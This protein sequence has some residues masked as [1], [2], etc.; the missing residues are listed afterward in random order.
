VILDSSVLLS[1]IFNEKTAAWCLDQIHQ[2]QSGLQMSTVNL[3]ECLIV[4]QDRQPRDYSNIARQIFSAGI[5]FVPPSPEQ[6]VMAAGARHK[7]PINLG[8][9]FAYALAAWM[10]LPLLT[11]DRDFLKTDAKVIC[12]ATP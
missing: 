1:V 7:F 11:L 6:S 2:S 4:A 8:D 9:C 12:P 5:E 3:T 10:N